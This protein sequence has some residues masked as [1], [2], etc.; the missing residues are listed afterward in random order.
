MIKVGDHIKSVLIDDI[1]YFYSRDKATYLKT[2]EGR[3]FLLDY[4]LEQLSE[5]L[6]PQSYYRINRKYMVNIKAISDI[7]AYSNSRLELQLPHPEENQIIVS[8][9]RV[10][11]FKQWLDR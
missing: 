9:E 10:S 6:D 7:I 2:F 5:M 11:D 3:S 8:R 4:S 1:A